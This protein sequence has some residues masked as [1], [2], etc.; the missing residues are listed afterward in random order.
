MTAIQLW[1]IK[2][3][4]PCLLCVTMLS[5]TIRDN[6]NPWYLLKYPIFHVEIVSEYTLRYTESCVRISIK[7]N[8]YLSKTAVFSVLKSPVRSR[9]YNH[10]YQHSLSIKTQIVD[11]GNEL[12]YFFHIKYY[13]TL[14][15]IC[16]FNQYHKKIC[17]FT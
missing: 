17:N 1:N 16:T 8:M 15:P 7:L 14:N 3:S 2:M 10:F 4:K 13:H 5:S 12:E 6:N 9:F 11:W